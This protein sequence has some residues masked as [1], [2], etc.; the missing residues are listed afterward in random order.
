[1]KA[2]EN[3]KAAN[4]RTVFTAA[5]I[6][7]S[8]KGSRGERVDESGPAAVQM[9]KEAGYEVVEAMIIP[10]EPLILKEQM[11]RLT[12]EV[13]VNLI[14]T[15]G[16]TG[17]SM[18]DQTPEATME[19][20]DRTAPGIAEY[21]RMCSMQKTRR[22]ML[23]RGVSVIRKQTLII[24][25]PGSEKA[26]KEN[27]LVVMDSVQHGIDMLRSSGSADCA[28]QAH[29][30]HQK[31]PSMDMWMQEA[32]AAP[33]APR[34]GMYLT[35]SGIV[36]ETA[37][38]AVRNGDETSAPVRGV[39]F[40]YDAAKVSAAIQDTYQLDGIYNI[41][42]WLNEGMLQ[43]GDDIMQVLIG[44]DIRPHVVDALQYLVGRLKEECVTETEL[45]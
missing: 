20:A 5:V 43:V 41:K 34:I 16:G 6:T 27:F 35:H 33:D 1:M 12:D 22:A 4:T 7:V 38:A 17:F 13:Q 44:G 24:N 11:V 37:K 3:A 19:I 29:P 39:L 23:S 10:D 45:H 9:L 18:R 36:R 15:S 14:L 25:L 32:K 40:S 42:V 2:D 8:D 21:I 28:Q 31:A 30:L 26:A